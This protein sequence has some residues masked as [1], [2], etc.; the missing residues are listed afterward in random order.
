MLAQIVTNSPNLV[1]DVAKVV[2]DITGGNFD[3]IVATVGAIFLLARTLRKV[4]PDTWQTGKVGEVLK[5]AALEINPQVGGS[6]QQPQVPPT[7]KS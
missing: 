2:Q 7:T 4:V 1:N 6:T 5:H 3:S